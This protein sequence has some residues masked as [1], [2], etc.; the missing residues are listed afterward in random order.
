[1]RERVRERGEGG[2]AEE[3]WRR[4]REVRERERRGREREREER[5]RE[6]R[7]L[8]FCASRKPQASSLVNFHKNKFED[9]EQASA[10]SEA[11]SFQYNGKISA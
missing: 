10:A 3:D 7:V 6:K 11:K 2:E 8:L 9:Y 1:M 4:E 5:E